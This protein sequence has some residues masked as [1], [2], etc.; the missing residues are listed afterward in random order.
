MNLLTF[1][2]IINHEKV[3]L[4]ISPRFSEDFDIIVVGGGTAGVCA[5]LAAAETK[6]VLCIERGTFLGGMGSGIVFGYYYGSELEDQ[7][8][9]N[10]IRKISAENYCKCKGWCAGIH[11]DAKKQVYQ[12]RYLASGGKLMYKS[13]VTGVWM[14]GSSAVGLRVLSGGTESDISARFVIDTTAEANVCRLAGFETKIGRESDGQCQAY[15]L[16]GIV[17]NGCGEL[18]H[19]YR[20][21]GFTD[22]SDCFEVSRAVTDGFGTLDETGAYTSTEGNR[23][24]SLGSI[25]GKRE[26][27]TIV[28]ED[29]LTGEQMLNFLPVDKPLFY[30]SSTYDTH[31]YDPEFETETVQEYRYFVDDILVQ[32]VPLGALVPKGGKNILAAGLGMDIDHDALASVRLKRNVMRSGTAAAVA[33][34]TAIDENCDVF[35]CYDKIAEK[36]KKTGI[37]KALPELSEIARNIPEKAAEYFSSKSQKLRDSAAYYAARIMTREELLKLLA[38]KSTAASAAAA[39]AMQGYADGA[40]Y[41]KNKETRGA[42]YLLGKI[43]KDGKYTDLLAEK[44]HGNFMSTAFSALVRNAA[45]GDKKAEKLVLELVGSKDFSYKLTLNGKKNRTVLERGETFRKYIRH[46]LGDLTAYA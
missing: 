1:N 11:P 37:Y 9:D 20:D 24:L 46:F 31:L 12:N 2:T 4:N 7:S 28:G 45:N 5:A 14:E 38:D 42:V 6:K 22:T 41:F 3:K 17:K 39:L 18:E 36:L 33:A 25:F 30:T 27:V 43:N 16:V 44:L 35:A 19:V 8:L 15:S 23:L 26:G 32:P 29:S 34:Q 21:N 13:I 10:D 40:D